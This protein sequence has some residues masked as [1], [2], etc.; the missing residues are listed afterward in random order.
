MQ[1]FPLF[2][3]SVFQCEISFYQSKLLQDFFSYAVQPDSQREQAC[4]ID[5]RAAPAYQGRLRC[6][7][8]EGLSFPEAHDDFFLLPV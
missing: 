2:T 4:G 5:Q 1:T 3:Y 7:V 8:W 6:C